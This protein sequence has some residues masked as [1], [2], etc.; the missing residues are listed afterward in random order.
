MNRRLRKLRQKLAENELDALLISQPENRRYLSGFAGS[1]G[2]LLISQDSA[3]LATDFRYV[4]QATGQAP[5]FQVVQIEGEL[6]KWL[7]ELVSG[8][9]ARRLGFEGSSLSF[10]SYQQLTEAISAIERPPELVPTQGLVEPLRAIKDEEELGCIKKAVALAEAAFENVIHGVRP[11]MTEKQ[12][13]WELEKFLRENGS[14][15]IPFGIIVASGP[16]SA[17]PH[18]RPTERRI[19]SGEPVVIDFG[20]RVHGYSSDLTRTIYLGEADSTFT[21]V[22]DIVLRAQLT[23]IDALE[24]GMAGE[25]ADQLGRMVIEQAGYGQAFGH[26]LGHGVG[27]A[28]HEE[29]RLGRGSADRLADGMVFTVEPGIYLPGWGGVR[30]EDMVVLEKGK[31]KVLSKARKTELGGDDQHQ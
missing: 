25:Q 2:F 28:V 4:E 13:A 26:G 1:A 10:A 14:G 11:G 23:A 30:I 18:A 21:K 12:V 20:A 9:G 29:P 7:P 6:P 22:Y 19:L 31:A 27:L 24:S 17:L 3:I 8:L 5:D 15:A 16:N